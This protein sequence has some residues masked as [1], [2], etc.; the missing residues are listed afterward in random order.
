MAWHTLQLWNLTPLRVFC[1]FQP[2]ARKEE[3]KQIDFLFIDHVKH[4]YL[5]DLKLA[6]ELQIL[7][8]GCVVVGDNILYPGS[9]DYKEYMLSEGRKLF[10]T[11]AGVIATCGRDGGYLFLLISWGVG[12]V[13]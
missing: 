9:P 11:E 7:A 13:K 1:G 6:L 10:K 3:G 4:L 8:K 2:A 5:S 12:S